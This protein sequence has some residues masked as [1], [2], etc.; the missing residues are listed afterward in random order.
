MYIHFLI[1]IK[2]QSRNFFTSK[3]FFFNPIAMH[4]FLWFKE[5]FFWIKENFFC[6]F[7][8]WISKVQDFIIFENNFFEWNEYCRVEDD[9]ISGGSQVHIDWSIVRAKLGPVRACLKS[10]SFSNLFA[11][12]WREVNAAACKCNVAARKDPDQSHYP[13]EKVSHL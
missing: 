13:V 12:G 9:F 3:K 11:Q 7:N 8:C 6:L 10:L 5:I 2:K 4:K 1:Q